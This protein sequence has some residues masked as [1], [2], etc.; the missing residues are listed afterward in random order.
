MDKIF[1]FKV[2]LKYRKG[3]W[4]RI[5]IKGKQTLGDFDLIIREAFN[6]DPWDHLSEFFLGRV[7]HS[8]SFGQI[9]PGGNGSGAKTR[10]NQLG[11]SEGDKM[12]YV[13]DFGDDIQHTI[14]LEKIF[15]SEKRFKYPLIA[16]KNKPRYHYCVNCKK[17][18]KKTR[19]TWKCI[20]CSE[21]EDTWIYLCEECLSEEHE[22]HYADEILY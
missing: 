15:D 16:S 2:A 12:E 3:L 14:F 18:G 17:E 1:I 7:W 22:D 13:Y 11:L 21:N 20:E 4:R 5:E 6:H 10:I 8:E 9:E 19:A